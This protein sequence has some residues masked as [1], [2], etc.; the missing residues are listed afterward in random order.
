MSAFQDK[1]VVITGGSEGIGKALVET[2][3][4]L[5]AKVAT[6]GRNYDKLYHLRSTH[7][8]MPL[9]IHTA[10]V[11]RE[12]DCRNFIDAVIHSFGTID[13]LV[14]NAGVSMR[15]L[16]QDAEP[17]AIRKVM[18]TNFWGTVL[19]TKF[20]LPYIM[21]NRGSIVGVSSIAGF[22]GLPGRSGYSASKF[23]INGF[24][25]SLRTEMLES[26]VNVLWVCPGFTTSN[27]RN[28]ALDKKGNAHGETT[29]DESK[30]MSAQECALHIIHAIKK[31]K[32][33]LILTFTGK[34]TVLLNKL[35]PK[36]ADK[37]VRKFFYKDGRLVK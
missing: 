37:L 29:M 2:F 19:C 23:A 28:A 10:D 21:H 30:M 7:T 13:I 22:R 20:A 33:T 14:N 32:R 18:D 8:H 11:S 34:R 24:F 12:Q 31:R 27:I 35:F 9:F 3:L 16:V 6:C 4:Q 15:A 1:V 25:E 17:E 5:G 26:G 36:F